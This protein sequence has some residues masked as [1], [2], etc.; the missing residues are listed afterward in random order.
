M[1]IAT[2]LLA[3]V[4][5]LTLGIGRSFASDGQYPRPTAGQP[6]EYVLMSQIPVAVVPVARPNAARVFT[7]TH[8]DCD[9]DPNAMRMTVPGTSKL[10]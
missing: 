7:T 4:A 1:R 6:P 2:L 3:V 8:T 5:V 10:D 9:T